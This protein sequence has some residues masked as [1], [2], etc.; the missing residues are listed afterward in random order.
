MHTSLDYLRRLKKYVFPMICQLG[1]LTIF[2]TFTSAKSKWPHLLQ[3]LYDFNSKKLGFDA[4]FD[5][6]EMKHIVDLI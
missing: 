5:K 1:P 3:C 2:V 6:L 4:P